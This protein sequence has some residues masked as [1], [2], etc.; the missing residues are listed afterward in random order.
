MKK[1]TI[2]IAVI[3][4]ATVLLVS[5]TKEP[6][7]NDNDIIENNGDVIENEGENNENNEENTEISTETKTAVDII[8]GAYD[9]FAENLAPVM[10]ITAD[11]A[12]Q[13]FMGGYYDENDETTLVQ[14]GAGKLPVDNANVVSIGLIPEEALAMIDDVAMLQHPMMINF[15]AC[16]AFRVAD[17][18]SVT[19][20]AD[21]LDAA[22]KDNMWM[23]GQPEGYFVITVDNFVISFYG[24]NDNIVPMKDALI[25]T[26]ANATVAHEG[27]FVEEYFEEVL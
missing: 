17:A 5:C 23:C 11:E 1:L 20:V 14:G 25:A 6:A 19:A 4:A 9:K 15:F 24:L 27:S 12:K 18:T 13:G 8:A 3:L 16:T 7:E 26:Y 2:L 10:G 22:I 21:A